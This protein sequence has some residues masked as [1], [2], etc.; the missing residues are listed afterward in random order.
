MRAKLD[1]SLKDFVK[2]DVKASFHEN[3][4]AMEEWLY[5]EGYDAQKSE[6]VKRINE[7][8]AIGDPIAQRQWETQHREDGVH[9]LKAAVAKYQAF[10]SIADGEKYAHITADE[11]AK[12]SASASTADEWLASVLIKQ[13][14]LPKWETPAFTVAELLEKKKSLVQTCEPIVTKK[15]PAPKPEPKAEEAGESMDTGS[16]KADGES[17]DAEMADSTE[18]APAEMDID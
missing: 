2:P 11:K 3:L 5:D 9:Q 7:L 18:D 4:N 1:D 8:R 15:A 17:Q 6:Y 14:K 12:V 16:E 10:A 13:D